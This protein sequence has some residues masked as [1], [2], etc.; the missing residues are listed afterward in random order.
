MVQRLAHRPFKAVIRV[1]FPLALPPLHRLTGGLPAKINGGKI[2][3][4]CILLAIAVLSLCSES[5]GQSG[6]A[7]KSLQA[8]EDVKRAMMIVNDRTAQDGKEHGFIVSA[9]TAQVQLNYNE[10]KMLLH[11]HTDTIAI[12][13]T[14][15]A[16]GSNQPSHTDVANLMD[17]QAEVPGICSYVIGHTATRQ[18]TVYEIF[19]DGTVRMVSLLPHL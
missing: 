19:P 15:P 4:R 8:R 16:A 12:F 3:N 10:T 5:F 7:F 14:H 1:R 13:H 11:V 2:I 9:T 17:L 6:C 18:R